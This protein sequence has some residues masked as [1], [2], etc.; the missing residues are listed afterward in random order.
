MKKSISAWAFAPQRSASEVFALAREHGF[1]AVEVTIDEPGGA[2]CH[3]ITTESTQQ[4]CE[5]VREQARAAGVEIAS[6]ASGLGWKRRMS[7]T[8]GVLRRQ[9]IESTRASL[10]RAAWLGA[11]AILCVPGVVDESTPY[12]VALENARLSLD[13]LRSEALRL[14]VTI[15]I[16]NV[17]NKMLLSPLETRDLIDVLNGADEGAFGVY[18]DVGNVVLS[19]Y[20]EHWIGILGP[21]ITRVHFKDFKRSVGNG[22]GFCD[23]LDGDVDFPAVMKALRETGYEGPATS[24]FF[25]CEADLPKISRAVD[26]ILAM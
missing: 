22:D 5:A 3:Q 13:E 14:G 20:P 11:D 16:E 1:P 15:A 8:D 9:A 7:D 26:Q 10:Q 4:Q 18:F 17:W 23:L 24:E 21:R 6:V 25:N 19:G 12:H 2:S